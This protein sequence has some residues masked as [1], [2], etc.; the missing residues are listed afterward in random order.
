MGIGWQEAIP[1]TFCTC[2]VRSRS[3]DAAFVSIGSDNNEYREKWEK[4][5]SPASIRQVDQGTVKAF[6]QK[7]VSAGRLPEGRYSCPV[8]LKRFGLV[9]GDKL[10]HAG[11][12]LFGSTHPVTLNAAI[13]ATDEKL[14]FLD[15]K[16]FEDNICNL[17]G[18]AEEYILKNIRWRSE[19]IGAERTEIPETAAFSEHCTVPFS[20]LRE[21]RRIRISTRECTGHHP[22]TITQIPM[23]PTEP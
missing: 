19:I 18:L 15:M 23:Q 6:W 16:R 20:E 10:N 1:V 5:P 2:A 14:T 13:F 7:A 4:A 3:K 21:A 9:S 8:I 17:L 22:L 12:Y 11:E